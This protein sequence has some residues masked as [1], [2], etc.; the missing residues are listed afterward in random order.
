MKKII[1]LLI[2]SLIL[3]PIS[4]IAN[5][6]VNSEAN[7]LGYIKLISK[8]GVRMCLENYFKK[9]DVATEPYYIQIR[10]WVQKNIPEKDA[11]FNDDLKIAIQGCWDTLDFIDKQ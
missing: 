9:P 3:Y 5:P 11:Q 4:A 6:E 8:L 2:A 7:K 1:F 10:L